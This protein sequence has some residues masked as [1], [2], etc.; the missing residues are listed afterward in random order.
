MHTAAYEHVTVY[1]CWTRFGT[2]RQ[3]KCGEKIL[4]IIQQSQ[5]VCTKCV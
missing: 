2:E 1:N 3:A 5:T 4:Q